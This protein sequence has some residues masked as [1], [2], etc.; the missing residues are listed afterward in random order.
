M[1]KGGGGVDE[2]K[3]NHIPL[4]VTLACSKRCFPFLSFSDSDLVVPPSQI[5]LGIPYSFGK[6]GQSFLDEGQWVPV[7]DGQFVNMTIIDTE[8]Q[9]GIGFLDEKHWGS[10]GGQDCFDEPLGQ[11]F[12]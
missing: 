4:V 2:A 11:V 8:S 1:L 12:F 10:G 6:S 7:F 5:K 9:G 3:W